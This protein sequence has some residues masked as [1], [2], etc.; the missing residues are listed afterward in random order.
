MLDDFNYQYYGGSNRLKEVKPVL[1]DTVYSAG[2]IQTNHKVY[3][4]ITLQGGA[5]APVGSPVRLNAAQNIFVSPDFRAASGADFYAH[6]LDDTEG[7][8]LYDGM[9]NLVADQ[10][11]GLRISWTPSGKIREVR[12]RVDSTVVSYRYDATGKRVEKKVVKDNQTTLTR[13]VLDAGGQVMAVYRDTTAVEQYLYGSA[14]LGS[15][16][17]GV[18]QGTRT[19]GARQ[20][21]LSN[22][23]GNV[24]AVI[25]DKVGMRTDSTW[26]QVVS[27]SDYYPFGLTMKGRS[28]SEDAYRYGFQG[29]EKDGEIAPGHYTAE[30]WEYDSRIGRRWNQ[31]P[32]PNPS[33]S[34]Y[35]TFANNPIWFTD[36][37]GD[38]SVVNNKGGI[39]HYDPKDKDK[40]VFA[41]LDG[42]LSLIG[43]LGGKID[44][45]KIYTNLLKE[46][47]EEAEEIYNPWTFKAYVTT[48]GKWDYKNEKTSI[49][50]L[51]N[52]G[53]TKFL[54]KGN[55]M[56]S[57]DIGNHHFGAVAKAYGMFPSEDFVLRQA[58]E[59]QIK[60]GTSKKEWQPTIQVTREQT[61][62]HGMRIKVT[63][64]IKLPPYGDD[65]R[66]AKWIKAGFQYYKNMDK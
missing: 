66:D 10:D 22:H 8:F 21:E 15:F 62:E 6:V 26:A 14:R 43:V 20:Y 36:V 58:G 28:Y 23:L 60:S 19:L 9:G 48:N 45:N 7:T 50:G 64:I 1:R 55:E 44:A 53:K 56:E 38:S 46:N 16:K 18:R 34:N 42:K 5:Y 11:Q 3:R 31:D 35:A 33:I 51:G 61:I 40:R 25:T 49:F 54:F 30:Y 12:S 39:L 59:F 63:E 41:Q 65:P 27:S 52:D 47:T 24:L 37:L 17:R 4:N 2:P 32:K 57:Q 29:Q 13:Y